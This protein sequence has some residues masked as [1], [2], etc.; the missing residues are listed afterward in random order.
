MFGEGIST[1]NPFLA[2]EEP[3]FVQDLSGISNIWETTLFPGLL[4]PVPTEP[5]QR[6]SQSGCFY[7]L[8]P[9]SLHSSN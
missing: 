2:V 1:A 7:G 8:A 5:V 3:L 9:L 4:S 6:L